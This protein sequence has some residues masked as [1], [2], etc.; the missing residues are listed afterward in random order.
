VNQLKYVCN[1]E[2]SLGLYGQVKKRTWWMPW[3]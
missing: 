2:D 3:R 1:P